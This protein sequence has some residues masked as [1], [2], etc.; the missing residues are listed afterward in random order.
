MTL[1]GLS[2]SSCQHEAAINR[3]WKQNV[4]LFHPDRNL[5]IH[6]TQATQRLN[7]AKE[8]LLKKLVQ[9]LEPDRDSQDAYLKQRRRDLESQKAALDK[10]IE[11]MDNFLK[12]HNGIMRPAPEVAV[13][14]ASTRIN[15]PL[16]RHAMH[17]QPV[18]QRIDHKASAN[19]R[20]RQDSP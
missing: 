14:H 12:F 13:N 1:L 10:E 16:T 9:D 8:V 4:K 3:A 7:Q 11:E 20:S 17:Q 18:Y 19:K 2:C 5:S 15:P 6:A